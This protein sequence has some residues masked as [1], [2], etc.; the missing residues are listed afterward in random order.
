MILYLSKIDYEP[1]DKDG[2]LSPSVEIGIQ[3]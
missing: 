1:S 2:L 3:T